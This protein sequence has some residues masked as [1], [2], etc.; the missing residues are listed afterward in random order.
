[1]PVADEVWRLQNLKSL[2]ALHFTRM[3]NK[4]H[5]GGRPGTRQGMPGA[6]SLVRSAMPAT[7]S[8]PSEQLH[9]EK[10]N[11]SMAFQNC[12]GKGINIFDKNRI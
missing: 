5:Y 8:D 10:Q 7:Q 9:A 2:E 1:M 6:L 4:G 11:C 12:S 3:A